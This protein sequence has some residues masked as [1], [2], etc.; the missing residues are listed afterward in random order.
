MKMKAL[1]SSIVSLFLLGVFLFAPNHVQAVVCQNKTTI[2]F[3]N[4]MFNTR[5]MAQESLVDGLRA[6]MILH[7][8]GFA[9]M[10]K[11]E[12]TLAF[13]HDGS[14]YK[15]GGSHPLQRL[16]DGSYQKINIGGQLL[17]VILQKIL[18]DDFSMFWRWIAGIQ[19]VPQP[20]QD[21]MNN[22]AAGVNKNGYALDP[23]LQ[24]QVTLYSKLLNAGKRV[25][26]VSHSQGNFYANASYSAL[27][28]KNPSWSTSIGNVQVATPTGQNVGGKLG[29]NEPH[30]TV[31]ED[32]VMKAVRLTQGVPLT[33][34]TKPAGILSSSP[35][36]N[37]LSPNNSTVWE[38]ATYGHHFVKWYLAGIY[39]RDFIMK[40]IVDTLNG[41]AG[42]YAGLQYPTQGCSTVTPPP[43]PQ[44]GPFYYRD[45]WADLTYDKT[46]PDL[47][48]YW[49]VRD[50]H[51]QFKH[52]RDDR[53]GLAFKVQLSQKLD[54]V[55][56]WYNGPHQMM[57]GITDY[58][59]N[60]F[61]SLYYVFPDAFVPNDV[62]LWSGGIML[63][64]YDYTA[65]NKPTQVTWRKISIQDI[66][67]GANRWSIGSI[68]TGTFIFPAYRVTNYEKTGFAISSPSHYVSRMQS[69]WSK[70]GVAYR[71]SASYTY[72]IPYTA[73]RAE[74][75]NAPAGL[76]GYVNG[77]Y[78]TLPN[79]P[80][81]TWLGDYGALEIIDGSLAFVKEGRVPLVSTNLVQPSMPVLNGFAKIK[82]SMAYKYTQSF[83][84]EADK[85]DEVGLLKWSGDIILKAVLAKGEY[86][87]NPPQT[88][89]RSFSRG[90]TGNPQ[91]RFQRYSEI[92]VPFS[93]SR[94]MAM[95]SGTGVSLPWFTQA[96]Y[97]SY[98]LGL[99]FKINSND[100][101]FQA[102]SPLINLPRVT[103]T[104]G[105]VQVTA[106]QKVFMENTAN[107]IP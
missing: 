56:N 53:R 91:Y 84:V 52:L 47:S 50:P 59:T 88:L 51:R 48:P 106:E 105:I 68:V 102:T 34:P 60:Q 65:Y 78:K 19:G 10:T 21:I 104:T 62:V 45:D 43:V 16:I 95:L 13:A 98:K 30:I 66:G 40:G 92:F 61:Q 37:E 39:T 7:S 69:A 70:V 33:L 22:I 12:Y 76:F 9:N 77:Q 5:E 4:G 107:T 93:L 96:R 20:I 54:R 18:Q 89:H 90:S 46:I 8:Q 23:D 74:W 31:P 36:I 6:R 72:R 25:L 67:A 81:K 97:T 28:L 64:R 17:E 73:S 103:R 38:D 14:Q 35:N 27:I 58:T 44:P 3:S 32:W 99:G 41:V 57:L 2:V 75:T 94:S 63:L 49:V 55:S 15:V 87:F 11:Y 71:E 100:Q 29:N 101:R 83:M 42:G 26:I 80:T 24:N 85:V 86:L 82:Q 1:N 79:V